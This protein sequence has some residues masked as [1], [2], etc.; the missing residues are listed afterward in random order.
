VCSSDLETNV[1]ASIARPFA[2]ETVAAGKA[3]RVHGAAW[4]GESEVSK[5]E[6]S[7]DGGET[8]AAARLVGDPIPHA[9]RLWEWTW[10]TPKQAGPRVLM[11][12]A[13]DHRGRVQP[14][15]RDHDRR[16]GMISHVLPIEVEI[17]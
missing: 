4:A 15:K 11:A 3:Y 1:K 9:W 13:T 7:T 12:R 2:G 5:V 17:T 6:V 14:L 16:N 10:R 8:W